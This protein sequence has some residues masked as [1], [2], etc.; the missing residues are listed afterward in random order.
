MGES[1]QKGLAIITG[2]YGGI[3]EAMVRAFVDDG[4]REL[5]LVDLDEARLEAVAVPMRELGARV[6]VLACDITDPVFPGCLEAVIGGRRIAA[7]ANAAGVTGKTA[8]LERVLEVNLD[9]S[10]IVIDTVL[11]LMAQDGAVVLFASMAGHFPPPAKVGNTFDEPLPPGGTRAIAHLVDTPEQAYPLSKRGI[12]F[13]V[14]REAKRFA[15]V[16]ARIC[17]VSPGF[18]DTPMIRASWAPVIEQQIANS[19]LERIG[20]Q[21]EVADFVVFLCSPKAS[22]ISGCDLLVD[23]GALFGT[24][25]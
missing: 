14:R 3:G 1:A 19:S 23:G 6:D 17:A 11:P 4:W 21:E 18:I 12:V 5:L 24:P 16:G 9:G 20:R 13:M 10:Q 8:T 22:F 2:A 25:R 7:V 15:K